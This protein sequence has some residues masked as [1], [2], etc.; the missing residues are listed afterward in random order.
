MTA[1]TVIIALVAFCF[2]WIAAHA[3]VAT[4]CDRLGSF[5][6]GKTT[7]VCVRKDVK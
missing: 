7:Y 5:Y 6:V 1:W 3:T 4:E 2:G